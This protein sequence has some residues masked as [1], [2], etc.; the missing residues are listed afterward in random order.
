MAQIHTHYDNLRVVRTA[1]PEII[2][3][4]YKVLSQKYHPDRNADNPE[5]AR[6]MAIINRSYEIL[7][8]A[9]KRK[10]HDAWI[11][12]QELIIAQKSK[13]QSSPKHVPKQSPSTPPKKSN[14]IGELLLYLGKN[15]VILACTLS[16]GVPV[17]FIHL[18]SQPEPRN[19]QP[20]KPYQA[21][22][23]PTRP[24]YVRPTATPNGKPWPIFAG[25]VSGYKQI[26]ADGLSSVTVDNR[27]NNSDVFVKLFSI[28]STFNYPV[29]QFYIPAGQQFTLNKVT[30]GE[31]DI[32]YGDLNTGA[33][34]R[35]EAFF[36]EETVTD[37]GTQFSTL[38]MTLYKVQNGNMQTFGLSDSGFFD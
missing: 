17:L 13:Q 9:S 15:W 25:Y 34:A 7:S 21:S 5:A 8:D 19:P 2:R 36:L 18:A 32:R 31:Y 29:R 30:P 20:T 22:T 6:V 28:D 10:E 33:L 4:A 24:K 27:Q 35:S 37:A 11:A 38:T 16:I 14:G 23:A 3:A 12:K 1:L 26:N